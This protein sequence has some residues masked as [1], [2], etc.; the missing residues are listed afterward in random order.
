MQ[1]SVEDAE[2]DLILLKSERDNDY[3]II[4][5]IVGSSTILVL[6]STF[7]TTFYFASK[8]LLSLRKLTRIAK[9]IN[10]SDGKSPLADKHKQQIYKLNEEGEIGELINSFKNVL[11]GMIGSKKEKIEYASGNEKINYS[12]NYMYNKEII[13]RNQFHLI[14]DDGEE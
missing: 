8:M 6:L 10:R 7:F 2:K 11:F 3:W 14:S 5:L 13:W 1:T 4:V 12:T 9:H